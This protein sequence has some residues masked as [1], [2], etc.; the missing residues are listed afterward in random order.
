MSDFLGD[1]AG[2]ALGV[3]DI[4]RP[5][6][7]STFER[8]A[9][10]ARPRRLPTQPVAVERADD[11]ASPAAPPAVGVDRPH[12][13]PAAQKRATPEAVAHD[14]PVR[15]TRP[16][17]PARPAPAPPAR[18]MPL[19]D[20][21]EP[22]AAQPEVREQSGL[23]APTVPEQWATVAVE[24]RTVAPPADEPATTELA[25]AP[26][27]AAR[28]VSPRVRTRE[29]AD[30]AGRAPAPAPSVR[31]QAGKEADAEPEPVVYVHIGRI[32]V[33]APAAPARPQA[34]RPREPTLSLAD[35]L[36]QTSGRRP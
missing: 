27:A 6:P 22:P 18:R 17:P 1:L 16:A 2:R 34:P 13:A 36:A 32:E 15:S 31:R 3:S 23:S 20:P 11:P 7:A 29:R 14:P 12:A 19:E 5:R 21:A 30:S 28:V 33:R 8:P 35:Y 4:L 26:A 25:V 10:D 24:N 9:P